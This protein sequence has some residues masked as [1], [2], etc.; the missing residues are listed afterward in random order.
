MADANI[1][2]KSDFQQAERDFKSLASSSDYTRAKIEKFQTSFKTE[3]I[4]KFIDRNKL[5]AIAVKATQGPAA[6]MQAEMKGLQ[7]EIQRLI[8]SGLSPEDASVKRLQADYMKLSAEMGKN[9]TLAGNATAQ[10]SKLSIAALSFAGAM[11]TIVGAYRLFLKPAMDAE[12]A[13]SKFNT[14]F[15]DQASA[16]RSWAD[17][18]GEQIGRSSLALQSF[19]ADMMAIV[20]P[21]GVT[22][23]AAIEMSEGLTQAAQ[24]IAS[25]HNVDVS[26]AFNA[27]RA[28]IT[29]ETE[30]LK[31]FSI[32]LTDAALQ[33]YALTQ[34]IN[35]KI[36]AMTTAEKT[37]LRYNAILANMGEASGDAART[38]GSLTNQL[39]SLQGTLQDVSVTIGEE[40]TPGL[41][42]LT[43]GLNM[44]AQDNNSMIVQGFVKIAGAIGGISDA[45]GRELQAEAYARQ[46]TNLADELGLMNDVL[47]AT[48]GVMSEALGEAGLGGIDDVAGMLSNEI[49]RMTVEFEVA[50]HKAGLLEG[51]LVNRYGSIA[52]AARHSTDDQ[53]IQYNRLKDAMETLRTTAERTF[54]WDLRRGWLENIADTSRYATP[55]LRAIARAQEQA[56]RAT[57]G[58]TG[59][60]YRAR[61][62]AVKKMA[63]RTNEIEIAANEMSLENLSNFMVERAEREG[64]DAEA[65]MQLLQDQA[66][67]INKI[68]FDS[69]DAR[70]RYVKAVDEAIAA[71]RTKNF[72]RAAQA[73]SQMLAG[74]ASLFQSLLQ[75]MQNAGKSSYAMA[76]TLKTISAAEA[77]VNSYLAFTQVL[78]DK[79]IWPTWA[80]IPIAGVILAAGLAKATAIATTPIP[81]AETGITDYTV[82]ETRGTRNDKAAVMAQG[83]EKV[84]ITPRG[85]DSE[86]NLYIDIRMDEDVF[87]STMQRGIDTGRVKVSTRNIGKTAF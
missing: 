66:D 35:K 10:Y 41:T 57:R 45:F 85:E 37:Q 40:A 32:L 78:D 48:P 11:G 67:A 29:G 38:S 18:Y 82:P 17:T 1:K 63:N 53:V 6:A 70:L 5:A 39:R 42:N 31:R 21:M 55:I 74:T 79:T 16:V 49:G 72:H 2:I 84:T 23:Q 51:V 77:L 43:R 22:Q 61:A 47:I 69:E 81:S 28:G 14:I 50:S 65:R 3:Q 13:A 36:S 71:E 19:A 62:D 76:V 30:P 33:E 8:K 56:N 75:I 7:R 60:G 52:E 34:G 46:I 87:F 68:S 20:S 83:G 26:E 15:G 80:R 9:S 25:F 12:E 86:R 44:V 27:L 4:D 24:D 54:E 59:A 58:A 64:E 73:G